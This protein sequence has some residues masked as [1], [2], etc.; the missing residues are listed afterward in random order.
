MEKHYAAGFL[1]TGHTNR[2]APRRTAGSWLGTSRGAQAGS[3]LPG[4]TPRPSHL[5]P[6]ANSPHH[7][8][9]HCHPRPPLDALLAPM[10]GSA[11][12]T[13]SRTHSPVPGLREG[14]RMVGA[15]QAGEVSGVH[16]A[17]Q[18]AAARECEA[19][20]ENEVMARSEGGQDDSRRNQNWISSA[21]R[22]G[23]VR[24]AERGERE[25]PCS[26]C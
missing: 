12:R 14:V 26:Q 5:L 25:V 2:I 22:A 3:R 10:G 6:A 21:R 20:P 19:R 15:G 7:D 18:G 8:R 11:L 17:V 1:G 23:A 4:H 16:V 24:R 9:P 13:L